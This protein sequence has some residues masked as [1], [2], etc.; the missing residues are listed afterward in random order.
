MAN[1]H[2]GE[3]AAWPS[4]SSAT[5]RRWCVFNN[6][7]AAIKL[8]ICAMWTP[9]FTRTFDSADDNPV[10]SKKT[11]DTRL[12]TEELR[13]YGASH[14][15][16][17][18]HPDGKRRSTRVRFDLCCELGIPILK[19]PVPTAMTGFWWRRSRRQR[20]RFIVSTGGSSLK[21][22]RRLGY[23][24]RLIVIFR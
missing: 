12:Q 6:V 21:R 2:L 4:R 16:S 3:P 20:K 7:R 19:S 22:H 5:M 1:N 17:E 10:T 23:I 24:L 11:L 15:G 18:L 9:S 14:S 8:P 13:H